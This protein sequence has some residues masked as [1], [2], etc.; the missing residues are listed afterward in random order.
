LCQA[1]TDIA[2]NRRFFRPQDFI[3]EISQAF[4]SGAPKQAFFSCNMNTN[5]DAGGRIKTGCGK[6]VFKKISLIQLF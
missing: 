1:I 3:F 6:K 5:P 2:E 4:A